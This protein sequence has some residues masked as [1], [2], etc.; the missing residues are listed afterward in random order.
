[1]KVELKNVGKKYEGND[2]YT[3]ENINLK[4]ES[5]DFCVILGPSGCG[6]S[7]LLRM[8][9]GLNS[10]T[11]GELLFDDKIMNKVHSKDRNIAMV[12][13]SYALYPHMT[14]Y[15]NMAFSLV[16]RKMDKK[17]IHERV[18]EAAK[19]LQIEKYLY[20]KPSDISG[21]QRQRVALG[22]A[23]VRK[24]AVFLMDEPLSN[25]DA[26]L[27]EHMRIELVKIHRNLDTT[28]IYVTH[29]QTEAMTMGTRI[30]LMND[31]K[32]QQ[33]GKPE[34]FYNNLKIYL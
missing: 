11:T 10:I 18:L 16:M 24:P 27:R 12:F 23:I 13:Q 5:K 22:R 4:I 9:A 21:G 15:D 34:E 17:M 28:T 30:V 2:V 6:K 1:M 33:V 26:K 31:S 29:D 19:I 3:L 7:T 20:S 32:I 25:L 14:V 8:I